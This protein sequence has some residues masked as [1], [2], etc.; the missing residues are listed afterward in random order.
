MNTS[1]AN[2]SHRFDRSITLQAGARELGDRLAKVDGLIDWEAFRP[3]ISPM[4]CNRTPKGGRPNVDEVMMVKLLVL[5][6]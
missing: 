2:K 1:L 6:Q 4:Y 5:Q 3:I